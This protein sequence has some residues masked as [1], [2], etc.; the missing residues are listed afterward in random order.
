MSRMWAAML[1]LLLGA[2]ADAQLE[3]PSATG[4]GGTLHGAAAALCQPG[5]G[6]LLAG[7]LGA[8]A[9]L[10]EMQKSIARVAQACE[11]GAASRRRD[12]HFADAPS[13]SLLTRLLMAEGDAA[14]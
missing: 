9:T 3:D 11:D 7:D 14:E 13:Q 10:L 6:P 1:S 12:R 5:A 4:G 2:P 8:A